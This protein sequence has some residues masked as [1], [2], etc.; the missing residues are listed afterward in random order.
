MYAV[1]AEDMKPPLS[2]REMEAVALVI[3]LRPPEQEFE[4]D[5]KTPA[6]RK[7]NWKKLMKEA[8]K[9]VLPL[10]RQLAAEH[11]PPGLDAGSSS[12]PSMQPANS[13]PSTSPESSEHSESPQP[14]HSEGD[15]GDKK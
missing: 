3:A 10:L 13:T 5:E 14:E 15:R 9:D 12:G 7:E 11:R 6:Q 1:E 2:P 4:K 8:R